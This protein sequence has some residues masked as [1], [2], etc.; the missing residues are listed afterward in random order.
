[1]LGVQARLALLGS[2]ALIAYAAVLLGLVRAL[3]LPLRRG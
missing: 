3:S 2:V 1:V